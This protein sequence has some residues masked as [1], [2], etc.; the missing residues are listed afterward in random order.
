MLFQTGFLFYIKIIDILLK[1]LPSA[2]RF[3]LENIITLEILRDADAFPITQLI[4]IICKILTNVIL[5]SIFAF[6]EIKMN[7]MSKI[8]LI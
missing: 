2:I 3:I 5:Y 8:F 7:I 6:L 4:I 1:K